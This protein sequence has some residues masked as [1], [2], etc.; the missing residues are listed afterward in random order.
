MTA[1]NERGANFGIDQT[2]HNAAQIAGESRRKGPRALDRRRLPESG[3]M[4]GVLDYFN[5][6][7]TDPAMASLMSISRFGVVLVQQPLLFEGDNFTFTIGLRSN[8]DTSNKLA[9]LHAGAKPPFQIEIS[10][11]SSDFQTRLTPQEVA[12]FN[13]LRNEFL[14]P[15]GVDEGEWKVRRSPSTIYARREL[16][17]LDFTRSGHDDRH[18]APIG[19]VKMRTL[20]FGEVDARLAR[21]RKSLDAQKTS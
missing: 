18:E 7:F 5:A 6:I 8:P 21:A 1:P 9:H 2:I 15:E 20:F 10:A 16:V 13:R 4:Q 3:D 19:K 11:A 17:G 12:R 14:T